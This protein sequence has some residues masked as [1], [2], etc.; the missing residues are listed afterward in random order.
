MTGL[1]P[2]L[3][4]RSVGVPPTLLLLGA[5]CDDIEIGMGATVRRLCVRFPDARIHWVTLS[6]NETRAEETRQAAARFM[7]SASNATVLVENFQESYFPY[8]GM[9]LKNYFEGLKAQ[10]APE[11]VFTHRSDDAHQDHR[12]VNEL[13]WNT[14]RSHLI[15]EYEIPK[16]D[17]DLR[18]PNVYVPITRDE[19]EVKIDIL[20]ASFPSQVR[21]QWFTPETFRAT[22]RLRGIECNAS[23][24][25]AEGFHCRKSVLAI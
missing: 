2:G 5:H 24:G 1:A 21:R 14:F 16:Y 6:S 22:A 9:D 18:T 7:A 25:Y 20:M 3:E 13:T 12:I 4:L 11:I 15:M 17:G 8:V 10:I 19:L 23:D